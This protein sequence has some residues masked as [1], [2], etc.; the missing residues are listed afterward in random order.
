MNDKHTIKAED[1]VVVS[2]DVKIGRPPQPSAKTKSLSD[3]INNPDED[4][5]SAGDE[6]YGQH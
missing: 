3:N 5:G 6:T 1:I 2:G 4:G